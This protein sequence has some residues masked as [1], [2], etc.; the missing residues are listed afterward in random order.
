M[1]EDFER[2]LRERERS[3]QLIIKQLK[4][5]CKQIERIALNS[6]TMN[7]PH[8]WGGCCGGMAQQNG[9][10]DESMRKQL[11]ETNQKST[12]AVAH[13]GG[14]GTPMLYVA[15]ENCG[16]DFSSPSLSSLSPNSALQTNYNLTTCVRAQLL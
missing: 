12:R 14:E 11:F 16:N 15:Q 5:Q 7:N 3:S 1:R 8:V 2:L 9:P 4:A 10:A 13:T 6:V